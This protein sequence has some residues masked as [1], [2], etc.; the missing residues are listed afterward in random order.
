MVDDLRQDPCV[1]PES[2]ANAL[3]A[4]MLKNLY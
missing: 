3:N 1:E 2:V 4:A